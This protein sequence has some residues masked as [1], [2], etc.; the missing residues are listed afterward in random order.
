MQPFQYDLRCPA[1]I[2]HAAVA[3]KQPWRS[4][5]IAICTDWG[6]KHI[7][8][9]RNGVRNCSSKTGSRRQNTKKWFG[10]IWKGIV[11]WDNLLTNHYRNLDVPIPIRFTMSSCKRR[12]YCARSRGAKQPW[13][14]HYIAICT[15][16]GAKHIRTTRNGNCSSKTGSR[17]QTTKNDFEEFWKEFSKD[18]HHRQ[19]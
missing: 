19:N 10:S 18:N 13:R 2:A 16:W 11:N 5:Y 6:A 4:L 12:G 14:S 9:T 1:S 17:R 15:D 7:R 8:T 3:P